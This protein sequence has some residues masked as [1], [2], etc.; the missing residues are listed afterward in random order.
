MMAILG[1]YVCAG[2]PMSEGIEN[3]LWKVLRRQSLNSLGTQDLR[4]LHLVLCKMYGLC[5]NIYLLKES[6]SNTGSR[7]DTVLSRK[8]PLEMWKMLYDGITEMGVTSKMLCSPESRASLWLHFNSNTTLLKGLTS[9]ILQRLGLMQ[10][11]DISPNVIVDGNYIYNL[12]SVLPSRML[13]TIAY[14][15]VFWGKQHAEN[16]VRLFSG[17]IF[18]LYLILHGYLVPRKS[19]MAMCT[20]NDYCGPV[21]L[22]CQDLTNTFGMTNLLNEVHL[23]KD[24]SLDYV[25]IFNNNIIF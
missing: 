8:V 11:V 19:F 4:F 9:Y 24:K 10:H 23:E 14:C 5:L 22:I 25:F 2:K 7:D 13:M 20:L 18:L 1:K 6:L 17:K 21:E 16:W 3:L 12:C 15:L